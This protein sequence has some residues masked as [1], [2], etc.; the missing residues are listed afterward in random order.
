MKNNENEI[1]EILASFENELNERLE[2][3]KSE[4][5]RVKYYEKFSINGIDFK[6]IFITTEKDVD[7]NISYHVYCVDSS[8]E[9][10]SVDS[11]RNVKITNSEL[12]KFLGEVDLENVMEENEQD[13]E[14]LKG[15]SE[16][17]SQEE[18]I[19]NNEKDNDNEQEENKDEDVSE[20]VEED[21]ENQGQDLG[22]SKYRK[23]KDSHISE[24]MP[25]AFKSG[26][27][28]GLAFSKKLNRFVIISKVDGKYQ[29][30]DKIEPAKI[31]WKSIISI[32]PNGEQ[33][34]KKVP[35]SLMKLPNNPKKEIAVTLDQYGDPHIET[36][37]VLPCQQRIARA[38]REDG[39][40]LAGEEN[41]EIRREAEAQGKEFGH[42]LAHSIENIEETQ[43][44]SGQTA[45]MNI[46][47]DDYI[48]NTGMTWGELIEDTGESLP[49]LIERYNR[50]IEKE[51]T[52][53]EGVVEIIE[54]DYGNVNRQHQH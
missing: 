28:N 39:E 50:E 24:K 18:I 34:E 31:T 8:N 26:I 15:I 30:N 38:V 27:E 46:T 9:I 54:Q 2:E 32:S 7:G 1:L 3:S 49:K 36:V 33:V 13:K 23:I 37:D 48:P 16:K 19:K 29:V 42:E 35:H 22:I 12:A 53:S 21:L 43:K 20:E 45:D 25:E 44:A 47:P 40:T 5:E 41:F 4:I 14:R 6:N 51:G 11:E 52:D 17:A 10:L